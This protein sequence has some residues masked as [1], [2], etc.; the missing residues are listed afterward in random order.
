MT[1]DASPPATDPRGGLEWSIHR[2]FVRYIARMPD[3][4]CSVTD[5]ADVLGSMTSPVFHFSPAGQEQRRDG[6]RLSFRGDV[7][8]SGHHGLLF[9]RI[10]DPVL[11]VTG[12]HGDLTVP[13][14][15][16][17]VELVQ[18]DAAELDDGRAWRGTSVRLSAGGAELFGGVYPVGEEFDELTFPAAASS[19][20]QQPLLPTRS[21]A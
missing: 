2:S 8:F 7:R 12:S 11:T 10:A 21:N 16:G 5:G 13:G 6:M 9:V 18:F 19:T 4:R 3:G 17:S 1:R 15:E 14:D 20:H